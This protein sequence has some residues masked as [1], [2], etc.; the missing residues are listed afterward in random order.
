MFLF[1]FGCS[2]FSYGLRLCRQ[3]LTIAHCFRALGLQVLG[4]FPNRSDWSPTLSL[5]FSVPQLWRLEG[6]WDDPGGPGTTGKYTLRS[7]LRLLLISGGLGTPLW[8]FVGYLGC[9]FPCSFPI[10]FLMILGLKLDVWVDNQ[11]SD[12]RFIAK[13]HFRRGQ[14]SH[15]S[16]V[17]F[18]CRLL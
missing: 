14:I 13:I 3:P 4:I 8:E 5:A 6:P 16:R 12:M 11:A 1:D 7:R 17:H 18:S 2:C 9:I 15:D 10:L